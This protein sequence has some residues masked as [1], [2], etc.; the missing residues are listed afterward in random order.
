MLISMYVCVC[1][2]VN[3]RAV[4][5]AVEAGV[6]NLEELRDELGLGRSCGTCLE[7]AGTLLKDHLHRQSDRLLPAL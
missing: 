1:H 7:Q 3:D 6:R 5:E 2:R 4:R